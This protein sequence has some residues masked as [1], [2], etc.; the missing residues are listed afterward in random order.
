MKFSWKNQG[1]ILMSKALT[2]N[3]SFKE[4]LQVLQAKF[5]FIF[6]VFRVFHQQSK[7]HL[8]LVCRLTKSATTGQSQFVN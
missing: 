6:G 2:G 8:N 4:L 5:F 1:N 7:L 3:S